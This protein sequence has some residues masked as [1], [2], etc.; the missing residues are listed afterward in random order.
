MKIGNRIISKDGKPYFIADIAANH[1]GDLNRA[2][3]LIELAK[4]SGA[5]AA[6]FQNFHAG[7]IV[8]RNGFDT[9]KKMTH[10]A[11]WSKSVYDVYDDATLPLDWTEKLKEKCDE[12]GIEY[13][14]SPYDVESV[15]RVDPYVNAY[16]IGS[17]DIQWT[18]MLEYIA[19][20][21][22]PVIIASGASSL[23]DVKRAYQSIR[24]YTNEIVLMQCNTNYTASI[25]NYKY[26]NLRV[27]NTYKELFPDCVLGLS[28]HTYGHAT[29]LGACAL[30]ARVFEKHF[31]DDNDR[32]G[33]DHKF[34]MTPKT[35]KEM[36]EQ[37]ML[38]YEA[39]GDGE[40]KIEENEK[41]SSVVQR[42]A[43]YL[44][45]DKKKGEVIT[46]EDIFP[47]RPYKEGGYAPYLENE[48]IGKILTMDISK[49]TMLKKEMLKTC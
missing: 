24:K 7:Q 44:T 35:W 37:T 48:V 34:S 11:S 19:S 4:E 32:I 17:G 9:M 33:P 15:D 31:T 22:K 42:R 28:D 12:V 41:D 8:S 16:K 39:L 47:L 14:T 49:D 18:E 45:K 1:D 43:I 6:K 38:L 3:K 30:G 5:D 40:K 26:I 27:L 46:K 21:G 20:K 23:E 36:V 10:Q 25:E 29:V 13:M 2:Y